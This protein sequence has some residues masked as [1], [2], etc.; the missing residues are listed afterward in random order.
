MERESIRQAQDE[1][2]QAQHEEELKELNQWGRERRAV[3]GGLVSLLVMACTGRRPEPVPTSSPEASATAD[4]TSTST[5]EPTAT[6]EPD[7]AGEAIEE[8]KI[9]LKKPQEWEKY[10]VMVSAQEARD[11]LARAKERGE[12]RFL[13]PQLDVAKVKGDFVVE[14]RSLSS[15]STTMVYLVFRGIEKGAAFYSNLDGEASTSAG[16]SGFNKF[17]RVSIDNGELLQSL[18]IPVDDIVNLPGEPSW[19]LVAA[20]G[21]KD[22]TSPIFLGE[23]LLV[24]PTEDFI[25][26]GISQSAGGGS[27]RER[28]GDWQIALFIRKGNDFSLAKMEN[29]LRDPKTG[30]IVMVAIAGKG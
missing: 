4:S 25:D 10:F 13:F 21:V 24:L 8:G 2:I 16:T 7:Y 28:L 12:F 29:I 5:P 14:N 18:S 30:K 11:M 15:S 17:I 23:P 27:F 3:L 9:E 26:W 22:K 1:Q 6:K 20:Y 19:S